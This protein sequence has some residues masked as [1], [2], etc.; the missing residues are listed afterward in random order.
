MIKAL[1][2]M[3]HR[4]F[5]WLDNDETTGIKVVDRFFNWLDK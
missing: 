2:E 1:N 5:S 3:I 4:F